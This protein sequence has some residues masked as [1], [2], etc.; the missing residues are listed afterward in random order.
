[1]EAPEQPPAPEQHVWELDALV[2]QV[3]TMTVITAEGATD[4]KR[5]LRALRKQGAAA[6]PAIGA[7]LRHGEDVAFTKLSGGELVGHRTLRQALLNTLQKIGGSEAQAVA[8][9][10]VQQTREPIE[11]TMLARTLDQEAPGEHREAVIHAISTV[12]QGAEQAPPRDGPDVGPLFQLLQTYGG[13]QAVAVLDQAVSQWGEYALLALAGLPNGEGMPSLTAMVGTPSVA[14]QDP[15]LPFQI[16]AQDPVRY[17]EAGEALVEL[18]RTGRIPDRAWSAVGEGLGGK[19]IQFSRQMF[20]G[21]PLAGP[22][23]AGAGGGAALWKAYYI[24]WLNVRYEQRAV[25]AEWSAEQLEQQL[26]LIDQLLGVTSRPA[27]VHAL[28][29]ARESLRGGSR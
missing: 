23:A 20:D 22:D 28:Q 9:E 21:T 15:A 1:V 19:Q 3:K 6:V 18:A 11:L 4:L 26:A 27:A 8:L 29:Q 13:A 2:A 10:Q 14:V 12:L 7:F 24:Q 25:S 16:L 5:L 17:P